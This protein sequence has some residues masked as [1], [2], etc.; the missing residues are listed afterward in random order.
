M[1]LKNI[2][3]K[4]IGLVMAITLGALMLCA[5]NG[6]E[7]QRIQLASDSSYI[8]E[9]DVDEFVVTGNP[10]GE[11]MYGV[12]II[13]AERE[14][15]L[16][17]TLDNAN[18]KAKQNSTAILCKNT[19]FKLTVRFK[20]QSTVI[21]GTGLYGDDGISG[22]LASPLNWGGKNG[23]AGR[24]ALVC[25]DV[26]FVSIEPEAHLTLQGGRGGDGGDA[27]STDAWMPL[28]LIIDKPNG[29]DGGT[30]SWSISCGKRSYEEESVEFISG[31]GGRGGKGGY[32]RA[33]VGLISL[34]DKEFGK[35]YGK[36]GRLGEGPSS[37]KNIR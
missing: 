31:K 28:Y 12:C 33:T 6:Y 19:S 23:S 18:F 34:I 7:V 10:N 13:I 9:D 8:V 36:D 3:I 29:G 4:Q 11:L 1:K 2:L 14:K 37:G 20:G 27:G 24:C 22:A 17:L 16:I 25:G 15:D 21:G 30:G 5:C 32:C 26:D 35:M